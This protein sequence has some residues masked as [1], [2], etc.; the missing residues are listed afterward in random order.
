M[1][2]LIAFLL[3]AALCCFQQDSRAQGW[4]PLVKAGGGGGFSLTFKNSAGSASTG[5]T[6]INYGTLTWGSGCS[7]LAIPISWYN[8]TVTDT[9]SSV[10]VGGSTVGVSQ[11]SGVFVAS[12]SGG[13]SLDMWELVAPAG[14]S[15]AIS[16]TYSG[17]VAFNSAISV[18]C[19][20]TTTTTRSAASNGG[21][22]A[23]AAV[24]GAVTV[25][26]GG[27]AVAMATDVNGHTITFTNATSDG[28]N[29][30]GGAFFGWGHTTSTGSVTVTATPSLSDSTVVGVAAWGP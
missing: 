7:A 4:F 29:T 8:T 24:A 16:V 18:Y 20:V 23:T 28:N 21:P 1:K 19:I 10:S 25:P 26:S 27:G 14:T 17:L 15:A 5:V 13:V 6:T 9:V 22:N 2:R 11:V 3:C 12:N 30:G